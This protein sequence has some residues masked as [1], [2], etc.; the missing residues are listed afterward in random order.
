MLV[1]KESTIRGIKTYISREIANRTSGLTQFV[2]YFIMPSLDKKIGSMYD[3]LLADELFSDL[4]CDGKLDLDV[5]KERASQA[6]DAS[7]GK[8]KIAAAGLEINLKH[9]DIDLLYGYISEG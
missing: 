2:I 5:T 8:L 7:G 1:T 4:F 3:S 6:M 9:D